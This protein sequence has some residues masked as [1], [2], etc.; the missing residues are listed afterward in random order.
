M[1]AGAAHAGA[2]L[3]VLENLYAL[4]PAA[5]SQTRGDHGGEPDLEEVGDPGSHE[6]RSC[7]THTTQGGSRSP[8]VARLTTSG[9]VPSARSSARRVFG[10]SAHRQG[11]A[12]DRRPGPA[13]QLLLHAGRRSRLSSPSAPHPRPSGQTWHLP[14]A[15]TRT[16]RQVIDQVYRLA[17]H[18]PRIQA[19]G[20][21]TLR[22]LG[23]VKPAD[24]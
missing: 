15:E 22:L 20:R 10:T 13:A 21:T 3:V 23:L 12:G 6:R 1:L 7:S 4:R 14:V 24:A 17:G 2:R 16:T 18:R 11:R 8:S 19:A 5:R 9:P